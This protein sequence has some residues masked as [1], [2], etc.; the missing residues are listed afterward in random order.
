[1]IHWLRQQYWLWRYWRASTPKEEWR[2][3]RELE[4]LGVVDGPHR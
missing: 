1:M 3:Y 2:A 4:K